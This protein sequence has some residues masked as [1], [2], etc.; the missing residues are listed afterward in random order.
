MGGNS[1][2][3][4]VLG[5]VED[6]VVLGGHVVLVPGMV[7]D[8]PGGSVTDV[9]VC[10]GDEVLVAMTTLVVVLPDRLVVVVPPGIVVVPPGRELDVAVPE[11][12]HSTCPAPRKAHAG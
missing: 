2:V 3:V 8:D 1:V 11:G 10:G 7:D 4:V 9:P 12:G 6:V 5:R